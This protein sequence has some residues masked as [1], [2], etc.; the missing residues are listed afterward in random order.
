MILLMLFLKKRR[1]IILLMGGV[2]DESLADT[3]VRTAVSRFAWLL[4]NLVTA[5][6]ASIVISMFD[7]TIEQMVALAVLMPIV[8]S[9]GG[10]AGTQTMTV[11]VRAFATRDLG[12]A[13]A[14][15]VITRETLVGLCKWRGFRGAD[16]ARGADLVWQWGVGAGHRDR[17]DRQ[18]VRRRFCRYFDPAVSR[19]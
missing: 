16:G 7:A 2:G 17:H 1:K 5:V 18:Y 10:N 4:V 11:T 6:L 13:N 12:A 9:M 14:Q 15:R 19:L 8:A 3:V